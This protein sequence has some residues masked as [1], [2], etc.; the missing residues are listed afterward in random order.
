MGMS[1]KKQK[2]YI[3]LLSQVDDIL[4]EYDI[5]YW[6]DA[7]TLLCA[8]RDGKLDNEHDVDL[9]IFG[10]DYKKVQ[11]LGPAFKSIG[12]I[13]EIPPY[14]EHILHHFKLY[15][16][17]KNH[18]IDMIA[19]Y[20]LND[21]IRSFI[22]LRLPFVMP[23][24]FFDGFTEVSFYKLS[25]RKFPAPAKTKEY[26]ERYF[27]KEWE[28]PITNEE[29]TKFQ[30]ECVKDIS[31]RPEINKPYPNHKKLWIEWQTKNGFG[32]DTSSVEA[33]LSLKLNLGCGD[34]PFEGWVNCDLCNPKAD[35]NCDAKALPFETGSVDEIYSSHLIEHFDFH[36][37]LAALKEWYRVL[38][39]GGR[40]TVECPDF[41][42]FCRNF[43]K[44]PPAEQPKYYVQV[45]GYPWELGQAH[46][47]GYTPA[48]MVWSLG[49]V[50]F[51]NIKRTP[52]LRF[53]DLIDW[54]QKWECEKPKVR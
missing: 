20:K 30:E 24:Y 22:G 52:A 45:W 26:L 21:E 25:S 34:L 19:W 44:L 15:D 2:M 41:E 39:P 38:K 54:C 16:E 1:V 17:N 31:V 12:L 37:G 53:T 48:Q 50:G 9:G 35:I 8:Y 42:A 29:Y 46:K 5:P 23:N 27:G 10:E 6:L 28:K 11:S 36:E 49:E 4:K 18:L 13:T 47:F 7:G 43:L 32:A 51:K 40:L 3:K 14:P 33:G